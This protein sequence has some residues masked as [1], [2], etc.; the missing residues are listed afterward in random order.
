MYYSIKVAENQGEALYV[1]RNLLRNVIHRRWYVINPKE[2]TY[3]AYALITY[4]SQG[5][6][7]TYAYRRLH[8]NPSDWIKNS[9][10]EEREFFWE[11]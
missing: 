6:L 7:T 10:S 4:S 3:K 9:R 8:T 2:E 11:F 1:I 5:E